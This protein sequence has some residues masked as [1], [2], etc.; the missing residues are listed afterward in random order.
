[1]GKAYSKTQHDSGSLI[2]MLPYKA[3]SAFGW[4]LFQ[5]FKWITLS[6]VHCTSLQLSQF[7][8]SLSVSPGLRYIA[9]ALAHITG[10][11]PSQVWGWCSQKDYAWHIRVQTV[12]SRE[13]YESLQVV[14]TCLVSISSYFLPNLFINQLRGHHIQDGALSLSCTTISGHIFHVLAHGRKT[15]IQKGNYAPQTWYGKRIHQPPKGNNAPQHWHGG[16]VVI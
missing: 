16:N 13:T 1:M 14:W 8:W 9:N 12:P 11:V 3:S 4:S 6:A 5:E 2:W 7:H 15:T 10:S